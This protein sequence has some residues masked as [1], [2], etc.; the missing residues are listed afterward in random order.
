MVEIGIII[1]A[2]SFAVWMERKREHNHEQNEVKE[3]LTGLRVDLENDIREMK[4]D[5]HSYET[6]AKWFG[7]FSTARPPDRDTVREY[8]W[9]IWNTTSLIVNS[10]RYEGFKSS[11]RMNTIRNMEL[12]NSI[13]DLYQ[14][15]LV[16]LTNN[17]IGYI[18]LKKDMHKLIYKDWK[19]EKGPGNNLVGLLQETG[20]RNYCSRLKFTNEPIRRYDSAISHSNRIIEL[21]NKEYPLPK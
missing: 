9:V 12:R 14:E 13:L 5:K 16:V 11:G 20:I 18:D 3:F 10:G 4:A 7:Y 21:I 6:Q 2:V 8:E 1:F 17:T 15:T 19:D